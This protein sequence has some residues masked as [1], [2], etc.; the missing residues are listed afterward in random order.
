MTFGGCVE[1]ERGGINNKMWIETYT[2]GNVQWWKH[3]RNYK[4]YPSLEQMFT[5]FNKFRDQ[6]K[7]TPERIATMIHLVWVFYG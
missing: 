5:S 2:G 4:W 7:V 6:E 3:H 1:D